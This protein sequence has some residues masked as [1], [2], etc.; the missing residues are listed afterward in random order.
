[1]ICSTNTHPKNIPISTYL[2]MNNI[3]IFFFFP[4]MLIEQDIC[5]SNFLCYGIPRSPCSA[6]HKERLHELIHSL[7]QTYLIIFHDNLNQLIEIKKNNSFFR[8][9]KHYLKLILWIHTYALKYT[10]PMKFFPVFLI[11]VYQFNIS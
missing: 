11:S 7:Y 3:L 8:S 10:R 6:M 9:L 1:L 5:K 2:H 4:S